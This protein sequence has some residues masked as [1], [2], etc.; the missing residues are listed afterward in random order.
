MAKAKEKA[1]TK[2]QEIKGL[3]SDKEKLT[4]KNADLLNALDQQTKDLAIA[5]AK[6]KEL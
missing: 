1:K 6:I 3:K 5:Q 4:K 2:T